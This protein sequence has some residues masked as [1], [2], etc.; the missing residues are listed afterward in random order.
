M[1]KKQP[2]QEYLKSILKYDE[3]TGIFTWKVSR[4]CVRAGRVAGYPQNGY[5]RIKIDGVHHFAHTLAW[6]YCHGEYL[7]VDHRDNDKTNNRIDNLRPCTYS[8][9]R[10]NTRRGKNN[11]LGHKHISI[12]SDRKDSPS[13]YRVYIGKIFIGQFQTLEAAIEARDEAL[14]KIRG[15]FANYDKS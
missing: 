13:P 11:K 4:R 1:A 7:M 9:N 6:L 5:T 8:Q 12:R 15:E 3:K 10:C 14:P 2:T